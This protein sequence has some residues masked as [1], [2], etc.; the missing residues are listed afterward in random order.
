MADAVVDYENPNQEK[1][2]RETDRKCP[3]CGGTMDFDPATG[4]LS[5][6]FCGHTEAIPPVNAEAAE[7]DAAE[8]L[9]FA[10]AE[11]TG[12][13]DWGTETKTVICRSCGAQSVYD[14]LQ[15]SG[16]CPYCGS[17]Q[18]MEEKGVDTLAPGGVCPFAVTSAQAGEK[19]REWIKGKLFCPSAAKR[20]ARAEAFRGVY[21]PFWTFDSESVTDY[22]GKYGKNR[23]KRNLKGEETTVTDWYPTQGRY[24][25]RFDD[26]LVQGTT[27][28][29]ASMMRNLAP[30]ETENN[31]AYRPEYL[32]G[33]A[34]ERYTVGLADAWKQAEAEMRR[35]IHDG[36]KGKIRSENHADE[37]RVD[38]MNIK[39]NHIT[40][41][42]L[43]LPIWISSFV[44]KNKP[45]H[46][47]VNG[48][49]GNVAGKA[50][51]SFWRVLLAVLICIALGLV[52]YMCAGE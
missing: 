12:N 37:S 21:L 23:K 27:R 9:D 24:F 32:A 20:S 1:T 52:L 18:V 47:M 36:V 8:E 30:F 50:P 26:Q 17:N 4:G 33:F 15:V 40:Y 10:A 44:Y 48:Q 7:A 45:Y 22:R 35:S 19:F 41:K 16:E 25:L 39:H 38:D 29:D 3:A 14:A 49:T 31:R 46:F 11:Q 28:Y 2:R 51:V 6:P 34:T 42:Y 5:C 43:M 13:C